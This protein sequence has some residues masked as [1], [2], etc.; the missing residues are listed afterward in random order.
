MHTLCIS[1]SL[2]NQALRSQGLSQLP[3]GASKDVGSAGKAVQLN[4]WRDW[5]ALPERLYAGI[6]FEGSN[7]EWRVVVSISIS[8][9]MVASF[10][11][12]EA[13]I[14]TKCRHTSKVREAN[15]IFMTPPSFCLLQGHA[16]RCIPTTHCLA[17]CPLLTSTPSFRA[18]PLTISHRQHVNDT[19]PGRLGVRSPRGAPKSGFSL[20]C[21]VT[22]VHAEPRKEPSSRFRVPPA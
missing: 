2:R 7:C 10:T 8:V 14:S 6:L 19:T 21:V 20:G 15:G 22:G 12:M 4:V 5:L 9:P 17:H 16:N 13:A 18:L 1:L 11:T 3:N